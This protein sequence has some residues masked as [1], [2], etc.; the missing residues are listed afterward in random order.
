MV[1]VAPIALAGAL[2]VAGAA[3]SKSAEPVGSAPVDLALVLAVD[4][5]GSVDPYEFI[6]QMRGLAEAFRDAGVLNAIK[7]ATPNG[8]AVTLVQW[9]SWD[10]QVQ[11]FDWVIVRDAAEA[12]QVARRIDAAPRRNFDGATAIPDAIGFSAR[13]LSQVAATRR[14]IDVSGDGRDNQDLGD[15]RPGRDQAI[16]AGITVNGLAILNEDPLLEYYYLEKVI[17][18][19]DAFILGADDFDDFARAI[20]IKLIREISGDPMSE[21]RTR[22]SSYARV[23]SAR[24][25]ADDPG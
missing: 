24:G 10:E 16:A 25:P 23:S 6:L 5:S 11:A 3:P 1:R 18:G 15:T 8:L 17:G 19:P 12:E 4:S 21:H 22:P 14:V 9:S 20:R 7:A 2:C 13:L